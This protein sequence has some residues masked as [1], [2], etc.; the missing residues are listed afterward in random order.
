MRDKIKD[1]AY[2][3]DYITQQKSRIK[4]FTE[5]LEA[6]SIREDRVLPVLKKVDSLK[7]SIFEAG[8]SRGDGLDELKETFLNI[9]R[10]FPKFTNP[11]SEYVDTLWIVS[12]AIMFEIEGEEWDTLS[13]YVYDSGID[14]W[15][16]GYLMSSRNGNKGFCDWEVR[17]G[18]PY[19]YLKN[20]IETSNI[21]IEKIQDY[22]ENKWYKAHRETAWYD[23]HKSSEKLYSGYWSYETGAIVK[24]L[25]LDDRS[26]ID[27]PY[28]P[29]DLVHYGN[30]K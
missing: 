16:L 25:N 12:I 5:K 9:M 14:D 22:L 15:L 8:Y 20:I 19:N 30:T 23:I 28:Y 6:G 7:Y 1:K 21:R 3:D 27:V 13:K 18:N 17:I 11:K 4:R 2:F 26:L 29:Y 24:I 10:D